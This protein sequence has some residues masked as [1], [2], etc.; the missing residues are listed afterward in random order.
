MNTIN[1]LNFPLN[2]AYNPGAQVEDPTAGI[3]KN[4]SET[5]LKTDFFSCIKVHVW[6]FFSSRADSEIC[7]PWQIKSLRKNTPTL[8]VLHEGQKLGLGRLIQDSWVE[9]LLP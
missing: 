7:I 4:I 3:I 6:Q 1:V 2:L 5:I 9:C 8:P